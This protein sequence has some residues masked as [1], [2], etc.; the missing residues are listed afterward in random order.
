MK[1]LHIL[2]IAIVPTIAVAQVSQTEV[3]AAKM[4]YINARKSMLTDTSAIAR[5]VM[6]MDSLYYEG[7]RAIRH[8]QKIPRFLRRN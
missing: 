3:K 5:E 7:L 8:D 4:K 6:Q 1:S 2:L